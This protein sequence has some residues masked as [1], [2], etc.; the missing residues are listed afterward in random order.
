MKAT[1]TANGG[2]YALGRSQAQFAQVLSVSTRRSDTREKK[3]LKDPDSLLQSLRC[4]WLIREPLA[5]ESRESVRAALALYAALGGRVLA[6]S[7]AARASMHLPRALLS[8]VAGYVPS[9]S[10]DSR[11]RTW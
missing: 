9:P 6:G 4:A 1:V 10:I 3:I 7:S 11:P 5:R 2:P 8:E